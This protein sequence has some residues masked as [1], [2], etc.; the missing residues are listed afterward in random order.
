MR[1][2]ERAFFKGL[3]AAAPTKVL[4][5]HDIEKLVDTSDEWIRTRT[6]IERRHV[7]DDDTNTLTLAT[8]AGRKALF[9]A[10]VEPEEVDMIILGTLTP[11]IGFP[12]TACLVQNALGARNAAAVDINAACSGFLYGLHLAQSLICSGANR[13]VLLIGAETMSRI[14]N[15]KDRNTCVL[16]GDAAGAALLAPSAG[17]K[18]GA[19]VLGTYIRSD[20]VQPEMLC[21]I[22]GGTKPVAKEEE[23]YLQM[24][25]KDVFKR[26]VTAMGDAA[27]QI[28]RQT[29]FSGEDITLLIP[30]Q[31]NM[32][33]IEATAR[34]VN[35]PMDKVVVN[36][37]EYGNTS[38]ATIPVAMAEAKASG[39]MRSGD[40]VLMVAFGA[41]MT[42]G[43]ALAR[44]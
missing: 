5:N 31:A 24:S 11:Y 14:V 3:G 34:R 10:G 13:N 35:I 36:I 6:G 9:D 27:E 20:G 7:A 15:W 8:E 32:R 19:G 37:Q 41:G 44:M 39:R 23:N 33:I 30:H 40:I 25:G 1:H 26:A 16:F 28:L 21:R 18:D 43:A 29:G 12:A 42:W 17:N 2:P 4:S 22:G 38:A